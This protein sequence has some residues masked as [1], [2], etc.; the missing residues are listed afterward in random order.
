MA[1][2]SKVSNVE[3]RIEN[4]AKLK[5]KVKLTTYLQIVQTLI[6]LFLLYKS[7]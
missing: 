5:N 3:N 2:L 4:K 6:L 7:I 1:K